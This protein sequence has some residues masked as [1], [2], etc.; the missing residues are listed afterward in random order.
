MDGMVTGTREERVVMAIMRTDRN[1]HY[2]DSE[3]KANFN[4]TLFIK[5][6]ALFHCLLVFDAISRFSFNYETDELR[7]IVLTKLVS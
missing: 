5:Q 1:G 3:T 4:K 7:L 2:N 6:F